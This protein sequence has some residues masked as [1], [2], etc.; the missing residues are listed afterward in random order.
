MALVATLGHLCVVAFLACLAIAFGTRLLKWLGLATELGGLEEALYAAGLFFAA[1]E[2]GL[3]ALSRFGWLRQSV[4]LGVLGG[5]A[6]LSGKGWLQL[7]DLARAVAGQV[8]A[9]RRS[10]MVLVVVI[11]VL[12]S[13]ATYALMAMA[14]LT[15]PDAMH[16]HFTVPMLGVGKPLA[17]MFWLANCLFVSQGHL[18]I[19]LGLALGSDKLS[20]GLIY[21]GGVLTAAALFVLSRKLVSSERWAWVAVLAFVLTP[22][23]YWQMSTSGSPDIWM[24]FYSTLVVLAAARGVQTGKRRWWS[25]AGFLAGAVAGAKYTGWAVPLM[26]VVCCLLA[27]HSWRLAAFS[28]CGACQP[29]SSRWC[30]MRRGP[31]IRFFRF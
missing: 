6:L 15:S 11:L 13:L 5:A 4:V 27:L 16:Y 2:V 24:A 21:L 18:L 31:A 30:A 28:D 10:P 23:V 8:R 14:P 20:L 12:L 1:L 25:V 9:I 29:E 22:M 26:L 17:P 3:F 7:L 19:A